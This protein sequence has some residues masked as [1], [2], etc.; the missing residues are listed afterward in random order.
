MAKSKFFSA[1]LVFLAIISL[2]FNLISPLV[3]IVPV[4]AI[5]SEPTLSRDIKLHYDETTH[6][7]D[8]VV[9]QNSQPS[10]YQLV[11]QH[12]LDNQLVTEGV[13]GSLTSQDGSESAQ[14]FIG[15]Y[16]HNAP[17]PHDLDH[18]TVTINPENIT[19]DFLILDHQ[20][21]Y[22]DN[23]VITLADPLITNHWYS[24]PSGVQ[25]RFNHLPSGDHYLS[26]QD[27]NLTQDQINQL[28]ALT[29]HAYSLQTDMA[30]G[31]FD[32]DLQLPLPPEI[33]SLDQFN[34][35][36]ASDLNNLNNL[37][38]ILDGLTLEHGYLVAHNID[39]MTIFVVTNPQPVAQD[40]SNV[41]ISTQQGDVCYNTIQAAIDAAVPYDLIKVK[42]G[43]Y[44]ESLLIDKPLTIESTD[45]YQQTNLISPT[46]TAVTI[47]SDQVTF[48]GFNIE[49]SSSDATSKYG[50]VVRDHSN[51]TIKNNR[52]QNMT[53][54]TDHV[55]GVTL[56]SQSADLNHLKIL[57]NIFTNLHGDQTSAAIA[58]GWSSPQTNWINSPI[59]RGNRISRITSDSKG[60]YG[61]LINHQTRSPLIK[62]NSIRRLHGH[63]THG[64]GLEGDTPQ[65]QILNNHLKNLTV[66][67]PIGVSAGVYLEDNPSALIAP[68]IQ[69]HGNHFEM[70]DAGVINIMGLPGDLRLDAT[71][72]WWG[73]SDGP[74]DSIS[75]GLTNPDTNPGSGVGVWG[76]V[77]YHD[78]LTD[79]TAP[80]ITLQSPL[81][82]STHSGIIHLQAS[83]NETCDYINFWWRRADQS[84]SQ[85]SKRYH[86]ITTDGT[87]F[88][89]DLNSLNAEKAD[90]TTYV[91][92][93]GTYYFYAAGKDLAGNWSRTPEVR[94]TLDN[95]PPATPSGIHILD[96]NGLNL[97]CDGYTNNRRITV[98]WNDN[99][100]PDFDHYDYM[101]REGNI[102]AHP[103][104]SFKT[105][106]IRNQD[107]YY[108]YRVR[109]VDHLGNASDWSQWCGVTLDREDPQTQFTSPQSNS[110]THQPIS[111][112]GT[113]TDNTGVDKVDI[114]YQLFGAASWTHLLRL[115]NINN[116]SPFSF[117]Y[118][119]I[120]SQDGIYNLKAEATDFAGNQEHT[121]YVNHITYD[122]QVPTTSIFIQGDLAETKNIVGDGGWHGNG[123]YYQYDNVNLSVAPNGPA[124]D[125]IHYYLSSG[126]N[127][128]PSQGDA[129]YLS[130]PAPTDLAPVI[131]SYQQG[132]FTLC[133]Y[134]SDSAG[135]LESTVHKQ[136]LKLD[137][138]SPFHTI[139]YNT[140]NGNQL[141]QI[142]YLNQPSLTF[143]LSVGDLLSGYTRAR[144]DLYLANEQGQCQADQGLRF[145][146]DDEGRYWKNDD[147]VPALNATTRT[148]TRSGIPDGHYCLRVWTYDDVQNK[149]WYDTDHQQWINFVIDTQ[150]PTVTV[151]SQIIN[152]PSPQITGTA[153]DNVGLSRVDVT[154][155]GETHQALLNNDG[156]W[157]IAKDT[158]STLSDGVYE[159]VATATDF[160]GNQATDQTHNE[161]QIDTHPPTATFTHYLNG[162]VLGVNDIAYAQTVAQLSFDGVYLD[163][164]PSSNLKQDSF[165]IFDAQA[166]GSFAFQNNGAQAYCSWRGSQNTLPLSGVSD[167]LQAISFSLCVNSLAEGEYYMAHQVYD[168][169]TRWDM[170]SI[171]QFRDVLGLHFIIDRTSPTVTATITPNQ[172]DGD[173]GWYRTQPTITLT[174]TDDRALDHI[175]Y[176][177]DNAVSWS[178]YTNP[179]SPN[180]GD[181]LLHYRSVDKAGNYSL[182]KEFRV[183]F[184]Q[185]IPGVPQ[186]VHVFD[187]TSTTAKIA[188]DAAS[189]NIGIDHYTVEWNLDGTNTTY[190]STVDAQ[191][192][193]VT[194]DRLT[195]GLWHARVIALDYAGNNIAGSQ[196]FTLSQPAPIPSP[197]PTPQVLG[198]QTQTSVSETSPTPTSSPSPSPTPTSSPNPS[199]SGEVKGAATQTCLPWQTMLPWGLIVI[200]LLL[201]LLGLL[202]LPKSLKRRL[203][204]LVLA[205]VVIGIIWYLRHLLSACQLSSGS[206]V[207]AG[208]IGLLFS[209]L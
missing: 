17:N 171:T 64:I 22:S 88:E 27:I 136:L 205:G 127:S 18:G 19:R 78:W 198:L 60:A 53:S 52:F 31:S 90:G 119:W 65:A 106:D 93:D 206:F 160:A 170:P 202:F 110:A 145:S 151:D 67:N 89:W 137:P 48:N 73:A 175:E 111:I 142:F 168:N 128:C 123:W 9:P 79:G 165:V 100:E 148:L 62:G 176:R 80:Q 173:N 35:V 104:V 207:S 161:L 157:T 84:Y 194:M 51:I 5:Q 105:G 166:D 107:G 58:L 83:C 122:T 203:L 186:N 164:L 10:D 190:N 172:P 95:T 40:C 140:I 134:A 188:W 81:N 189:D 204:P 114:F 187:V 150:S 139:L 11:Y 135:N 82:D 91:M 197:T 121:A 169:A 132:I 21:W 118:L 70:L 103:T 25:I 97:G 208:V 63:W 195:P 193:T 141:G 36:Y 13:N 14:V 39:H 24:L 182:E 149:A 87:V 71:Q 57:N 68:P 179:L 7:L 133:Y 34:L 185:T 108:K 15:T 154:I 94:I 131:N 200:Q 117:S 69:L 76:L 112:L 86:L 99:Q 6:S 30:N 29:D 209:L 181:H 33:T 102:I 177:W 183:K 125:V 59:I 2:F 153:S 156:T 178:I 55:Y 144:Y 98:D 120:P 4:F 199:P 85:A 124:T 92:E 109:A 16:S 163:Q 44:H 162:Q 159:V 138:Q 201:S 47:T 32:F 129:S 192:F 49:I 101:I 1:R 23:G 152:Y 61:I 41:A 28:R 43:D 46:S 50:I 74:N 3:A 45:G 54:T 66:D 126:D 96:H 143:D 147:L 180:E 38:T 113:S 174:A 158:F 72:N 191:T 26:F 37:S 184:D 146:G 42:P 196:D 75:D 12:W 167:T 8:I 155:N 116:N 77:D 20:L 56:I 130:I 115:N